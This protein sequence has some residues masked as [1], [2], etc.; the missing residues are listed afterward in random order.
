V[1]FGEGG[2]FVG[3]E[4]DDAV[5]RHDIDGG[6]WQRD[7]LRASL[8]HSQSRTQLTRV[9]LLHHRCGQIDADHVAALAALPRGHQQIRS[10]S[11]SDIEHDIARTND[12]RREWIANAGERLDRPRRQLR[13]PILRVADKRTRLSPRRDVILAIRMLR[14]SV[15]ARKTP[16]PTK[17]SSL[18]STT[19]KGRRP[20]GRR[21]WSTVRRK[22][23]RGR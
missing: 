18:T 9:D 7:L 8:Q 1:H 22:L 17:S 12:I 21:P 2:A 11:G 6:V 14:D 3:H 15:T 16:P 23:A 5:G 4:I 20:E 13:Q 19:K 10:R